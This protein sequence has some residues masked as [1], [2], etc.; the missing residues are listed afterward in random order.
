MLEL[1]CRT[2]D[3]AF[4]ASYNGSAEHHDELTILYANSLI[5]IDG[6]GLFQTLRACR[7]QLAVGKSKLFYFYLYITLSIVSNGFN[8]NSFNSGKHINSF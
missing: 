1:R 2:S 5:L 3:T 4:N 8:Q 6:F 7:N